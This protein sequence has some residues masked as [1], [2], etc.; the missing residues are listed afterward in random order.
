MNRNMNLIGDAIVPLQ[1]AA[2]IISGDVLTRSF[3]EQQTPKISNANTEQLDETGASSHTTKIERPPSTN[4]SGHAER[5][6]RSNIV[7]GTD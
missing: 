7:H 2:K 5:L 6:N 1:T 3:E 4:N